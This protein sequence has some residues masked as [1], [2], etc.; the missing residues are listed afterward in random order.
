MYLWPTQ[1]PLE[2]H[3]TQIFFPANAGDE[4]VAIETAID[5]INKNREKLRK[6]LF[7]IFIQ[8]CNN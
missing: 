8:S 1:R 7:I 2:S 6:Y 3:L 4:T 5:A